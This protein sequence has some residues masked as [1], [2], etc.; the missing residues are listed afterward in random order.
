MLKNTLNSFGINQDDCPH[1]DL[2][3]RPETLTIEEFVSII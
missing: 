3:R 2:N 1:I